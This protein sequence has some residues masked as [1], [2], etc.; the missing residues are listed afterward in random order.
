M[1][2]SSRSGRF[3]MDVSVPE[4]V[5]I[6]IHVDGITYSS[7]EGANKPGLDIENVRKQ[8]GDQSHRVLG[9]SNKK[10]GCIASS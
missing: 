2:K 3:C 4:G 6:I 8:R 5:Y 10:L 1:G 7:L 9:Y